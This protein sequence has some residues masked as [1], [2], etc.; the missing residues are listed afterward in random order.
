MLERLSLSAG[1]YDIEVDLLLG[2]LARGG[3]VVEVPVRRDARHHGRSHL[4]SVL[5]GTRILLRIVRLRWA[6]AR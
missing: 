1:R 6:A 4:N 5:D 2:V 3:R